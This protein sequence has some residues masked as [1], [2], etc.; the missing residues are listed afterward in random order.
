M[1]RQKNIKLILLIDNIIGKISSFFIKKTIYISYYTII[2]K[3]KCQ[4]ANTVQHIK[5]YVDFSNF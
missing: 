1:N 4:E 5:R 2:T 3:K